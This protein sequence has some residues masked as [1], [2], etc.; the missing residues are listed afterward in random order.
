MYNNFNKFAENLKLLLKKNNIKQ[1]D[2]AKH[3]GKSRQTISHWV[4]GVVM[5]DPESMLQTALLFGVDPYSLIFG[6]N[7][8]IYEAAREKLATNKVDVYDDRK[9]QV[10]LS[11][12]SPT[13]TSPKS[14]AII[15][16]DDSGYNISSP[17]PSIPKDSIVIIDPQAEIRNDCIIAVKKKEED[18]IIIRRYKDYH[19]AKKM[20][21]INMAADSVRDLD[22]FDIVGVVVCCIS[23]L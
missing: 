20:V 10:I 2:L 3:V 8:K 19:T 17:Y 22:C 12:S 5:P 4:R 9:Q 1:V 14:F 15:I 6:Q 13:K 18:K 16:M 11:V 7:S 23:R 21:P